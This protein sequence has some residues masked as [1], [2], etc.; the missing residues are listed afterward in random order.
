MESNMTDRPDTHETDP[1]LYK[2]VVIQLEGC[3]KARIDALKA[4]IGRFVI[5]LERNGLIL[6]YDYAINDKK[7]DL[8]KA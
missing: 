5:D 4:A 8:W 2:C 7:V 1:T 3:D 6:D